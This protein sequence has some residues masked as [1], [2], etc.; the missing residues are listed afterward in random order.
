MGTHTQRHQRYD[1]PKILRDMALKGWQAT[2]LARAASV[3]DMT[4]SRFL[5]GGTQTAKT[6][7][8]IANAL[9]YQI[10]RYVLPARPEGG[11]RTRGAAA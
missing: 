5:N 11:S 1:V 2:D 7:Q 4:V 6:A 8:K 3:S 10:R 9:G